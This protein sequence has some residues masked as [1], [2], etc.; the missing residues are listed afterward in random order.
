M[1]TA[2]NVEE[3]FAYYRVDVVGETPIDYRKLP[4]LVA[5]IRA[6]EA[7]V[8]PL[9]EFALHLKGDIHNHWL[10]GQV[11]MWLPIGCIDE[12]MRHPLVGDVLA[13]FSGDQIDMTG[14]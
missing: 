4:D 7:R 8:A 10:Y 13:T 12:L 3:G 5:F 11:L 2:I 14:A 1:T 9:R 6:F